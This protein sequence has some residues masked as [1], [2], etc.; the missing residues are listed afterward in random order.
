MGAATFDKLGPLSD[1]VEHGTAPDAI[2]ASPDA[3]ANF[4]C[5]K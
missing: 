2:P 3:A 1:W 4:A 5:V